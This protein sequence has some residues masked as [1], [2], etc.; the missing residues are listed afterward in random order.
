MPKVTAEHR[1]ARRRQILDAAMRCVAA[2]GFHKTTMADVIRASDL[3]AGAV[4]GYFR[5]KQDLIAAIADEAV[6]GIGEA[7][8]HFITTSART[9]SLPSVIDYVASRV[10]DMTLVRGVDI[11]R[12]GVAAW[13]EAVRDPAVREIAAPK[14]LTMRSRLSRVVEGLQAEG[15]WDPDADPNQ[16]AVAALSLMPGYVLQRLIVRDVAPDQ[17]ATAVNAL[18]SGSTE[19]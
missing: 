6:G 17:Y 8:D 19:D 16:V 13:A 4:Y 11:T 14:F 3:S 10:E 15:R 12:I 5:G 9:P 18:L 7:I 1:E 2:D